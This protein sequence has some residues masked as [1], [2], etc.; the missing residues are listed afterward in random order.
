MNAHLKQA[1]DRFIARANAIGS[2]GHVT[3]PRDLARF[4]ARFPSVMPGWYREVLQQA[5]IG[6]I[7]FCASSRLQLGWIPWGHFRDAATLLQEIP[8]VS[9]DDDLANA[10]YLALG[11]AGDGDCWVIRSSSTADDPVFL[12]RATS[13]DP[14][15]GPDRSKDCLL[16][17]SDSFAAFLDEI[18]PSPNAS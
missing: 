16:K 15:F 14:T 5:S 9:P 12:C 11:A 1:L 3:P 7:T 10:G 6:D 4:D 17:H 8:G 13:L 2:V 18:T